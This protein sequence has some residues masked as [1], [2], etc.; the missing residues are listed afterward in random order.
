MVSL[1]T[2]DRKTLRKERP[3]IWRPRLFFIPPFPAHTYYLKSYLCFSFASCEVIPLMSRNTTSIPVT[4]I[5]ERPCPPFP[6]LLSSALAVVTVLC[7][8]LGVSTVRASHNTRMAPDGGIGEPEWLGREREFCQETRA[9]TSGRKANV[10]RSAW[11]LFMLRTTMALITMRRSW[12]S[13]RLAGNTREESRCGSHGH[14]SRMGHESTLPSLSPPRPTAFAVWQRSKTVG[15]KALGLTCQNLEHAW[16]LLSIPQPS[17]WSCNTP[18]TGDAGATPTW[19]CSRKGSCPL[20]PMPP[21]NDEAQGSPAAPSLSH[22][23]TTSNERRGCDIH[24][25]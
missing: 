25:K 24:I 9:V 11:W 18:C 3:H 2:E 23:E 14:P 6:A 4:T 8:L 21:K 22:N 17:R 15:E 13:R 19:G 7:D 10:D 16:R 5:T 12:E 1:A 20:P